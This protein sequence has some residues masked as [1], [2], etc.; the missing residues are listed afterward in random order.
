M[1][2]SVGRARAGEERVP[3]EPGGPSGSPLLL[4]CLGLG[5]CRKQQK[6][7]VPEGPSLYGGDTPDLGR[8]RTPS[9]RGRLGGSAPTGLRGAGHRAHLC[10]GALGLRACEDGGQAPGLCSLRA[11]AGH[12]AGLRGSDPP[13]LPLIHCLG[14]H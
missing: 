8:A 11:S 3:G 1:T 2:R 12:T 14:L 10:R 6:E 5:G 7:S 9:T 4:R 13:G